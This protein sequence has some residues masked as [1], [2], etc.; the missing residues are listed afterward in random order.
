MSNE[1]RVAQC[2][3]VCLLAMSFCRPSVALENDR[4]Q[5]SANADPTIWTRPGA[6]WV[7]KAEPDLARRIAS[8]DITYDETLVVPMYY[9]RPATRWQAANAD[10]TWDIVVWYSDVSSTGYAIDLGKG[11]VKRMFMRGLN[12][13]HAHSITVPGTRSIFMHTSRRVGDKGVRFLEYDPDAEVV[14]LLDAFVPGVGGER[15]P[16]H[17]L[18]DGRI[19]GA[20]SHSETQK[21]ILWFFDPRSKTVT[22]SKPLGPAQEHGVW[23]YW[24]AVDG[25]YAYVASGK[26]PW[27]LI[28]YD[29]RTGEDQVI[30]ETE[31]ENVHFYMLQREG[32]GYL[33]VRRGRGVMSNFNNY[34]TKERFWLRDGKTIACKGPTD[35][36]PWPKGDR[37][38][39][40]R[41]RA[42]RPEL[43]LGWLDRAGFDRP[44]E[45]WYR[46][47]RDAAKAPKNPPKGAKP[48]E[49]G[50]KVIRYRPP[51]KPCRMVRDIA[52]LP[53]G[54][55]FGRGDAYMGNFIYDPKTGVSRHPA[56]LHLSQYAMLV[57]GG[58]ASMSGYP[59]AQLWVYDPQREYLGI[60]IPTFRGRPLPK[61]SPDNNPRVVAELG[62]HTGVH[63]MYAAVAASDGRL[64]FGGR[65]Y[66]AS[67]GGG[68][69]W[70]DP[71]TGESGGWWQPFRHWQIHFMTTANKGGTI[72]ISTRPV[73]DKATNTPAPE[74]AKLLLFE[75]A[76]QAVVGDVTPVEGAQYAGPVVGF[77]DGRVLGMT[78]DPEDES[79]A[80]L[81][82]IDTRK[83]T[84]EFR[85]FLPY[86]L[87]WRV[88][89]QGGQNTTKFDFQLGP[90]GFV[91]TY[92]GPGL[93]RIDPKDASVHVVGWLMESGPMAFSGR[94]LF[95]GGSVE[96]RMIRNAV[97]PEGT[98]AQD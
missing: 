60:N 7:P 61:D 49:L 57:H 76:K 78:A 83:R 77:D 94:D 18:P 1:N 25:Q 54:R 92:V 45:L 98:A 71:E 96:L 63:K 65:C 37:V 27:Y 20:G 67:N 89:R 12:M 19:V 72:V 51:Y 22:T 58:Q 40:Q 81:Y 3:W 88:R 55:I 9:S 53:D 38:T 44:A 90:D 91:W 24:L 39:Y 93:V 85:K 10:G 36:P 52:A 43:W 31:R 16:H 70:Y 79:K 62:R 47:P 30:L 32:G 74:S 17:V 35:A 13:H 23:S 46:L 34:D 2:T 75:V 42:Q 80:I 5:T 66:R 73:L 86:P 21:V 48:E 11:T 29:L 95:L 50:W 59:A 26:S 84:V 4:R 87:A 15:Q 33:E 56:K 14:S 82:G 28:R 69:G 41:A 8:S 68:V 64:Y 6:S 97:P